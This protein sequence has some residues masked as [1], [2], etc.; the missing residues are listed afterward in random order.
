MDFYTT[1]DEQVEA[2]KKWWKENAK[3]IIAG[4]VLG[5][6][7]VFGWRTWVTYQQDRTERAAIAYEQLTQLV[8]K[9]DAGEAR[10]EGARIMRDFEA[11]PY[12]FLSA[13]ALAKIETDQG[14]LASAR[15]RLEWALEHAPQDSYRHVARLRLARVMLAQGQGSQALALVTGQG[16]AAFEVQY[17]EVEGDIDMALG[18]PQQARAAY[19]AALKAAGAGPEQQR[20][21]MKLDDLGPAP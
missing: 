19:Q 15:A 12:A 3:A 7:I 1:E 6:G 13:L 17:K 21:Q 16:N 10:K 8:S 2:L 4:L 18:K 9:G 14:A 11:T 5:L 20:L